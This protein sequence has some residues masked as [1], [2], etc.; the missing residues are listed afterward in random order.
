MQRNLHPPPRSGMCH[1]FDNICL[2]ILNIPLQERIVATV[3]HLGEINRTDQK[4]GE[5]KIGGET[6]RITLFL[7]REEEVH[8][9]QSQINKAKGD[10]WRS[11]N[12]FLSPELISAIPKSLLIDIALT[13]S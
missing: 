8:R 11:F 12:P 1:G 2:I 5:Q 3:K 4:P 7:S 9:R 10:L 13:C 6:E